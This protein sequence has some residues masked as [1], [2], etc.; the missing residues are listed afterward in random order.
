MLKWWKLKTIVICL[1]LCAKLRVWGFLNVSA[2]FSHKVVHTLFVLHET[3]HTTLFLY[4]IVL[5]WLESN[6]VRCLKLRA[7][8]CICDFLSVLGTFSHKLDQTWFVWPE[9]WHTTLIGTYYR[10]EIDR[11]QKNSLMLKFTC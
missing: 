7:T 8:L 6:I 4:I 11:I 10:V 2:T 1:K 3:L 5:K 9:T